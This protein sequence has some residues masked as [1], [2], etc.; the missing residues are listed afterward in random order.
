MFIRKLLL[1][2]FINVSITL[3]SQNYIGISKVVTGFVDT[4]NINQSVSYKVYVKNYGP[5]V[6]TGHFRL[7]TWA[8]SING[9]NSYHFS[10]LDTLFNPVTINVG[11]SV[12][13][14]TGD[15]Y[16]MATYRVTGNG[17][18][19]WAK[20]FNP[21][22]ETRDS[23][24]KNVFVRGP[25]GVREYNVLESLVTLYPNPVLDHITIGFDKSLLSIE[26]VRIWNN[27]GQ[28]VMVLPSY[29]NQ[30]NL[31]ELNRGIYTLELNSNKGKVYKRFIKE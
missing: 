31:S 2:I 13:F 7:N 4:V 5:A 1:L 20:T 22:W 19:I 23:V 15:T 3:S 18:V 12:L 8:D 26:D 21:G 9:G 14:N 11:D 10:R 30:I 16:D 6:F 27:I 24:F 17:V 29:I 28:R 25:A